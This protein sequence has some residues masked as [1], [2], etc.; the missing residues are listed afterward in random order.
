MAVTPGRVIVERALQVGPFDEP[1][2]R[3]F[4]RQRNFPH[5][6][7]H[8]RRNWMQSELLENLVLSSASDQKAGVAG[9]RFGTEQAVLIEAQPS[10]NGSLARHDVMLFAAGK[11]HQR[12]REL[13]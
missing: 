6:L 12:E 13:G 2:Q 5:I 1:R 7:A 8:L 3:P 9:L 10:F 11:V 4:L